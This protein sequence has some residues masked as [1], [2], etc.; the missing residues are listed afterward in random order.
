MTL[1]QSSGIT[2]L[3]ACHFVSQL[4]HFL[5]EY[6]SINLTCVSRLYLSCS[7]MRVVTA[8]VHK[9]RVTILI[10]TDREC[11]LDDI[12]MEQPL[13]TVA[14]RCVKARMTHCD[15]NG[16]SWVSCLYIKAIQCL[17]SIG[18]GWVRLFV[19]V[20]VNWVGMSQGITLVW[21]EQETNPGFLP[22]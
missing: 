9:G 8:I 7:W 20:L 18:L 10:V 11:H 19:V 21:P 12:R 4:F 1:S 17:V 14:R 13:C 2:K 15:H 5:L 22:W 6:M 16:I 3:I